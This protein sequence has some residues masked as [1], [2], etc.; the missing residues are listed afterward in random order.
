MSAKPLLRFRL[1]TTAVL[2]LAT[3]AAALAQQY[4]TLPPNS[5]VGN[6]GRPS[7]PSF[8]VSLPEL[9][10]NLYGP[11]PANTILAGAPS[12]SAALPSFRP[13]VPADIPSINSNFTNLAGTLSATQAATVAPTLPLVHPSSGNLLCSQG[14]FL[15]WMD[16]NI[17]SSADNWILNSTD[18]SALMQLTMGGTISNGDIVTLTFTFAGPCAGGCAVNTG[19]LNSGTDTTTTIASKLAAAIQ[20]NSNIYNN[21]AGVQ[22]QVLYVTSIANALYFDYDSRTGM[23]LVASVAGI[24]TETVTFPANS[25]CGTAC[26]TGWDV[27]PTDIR[28]RLPG[29]GVAP[30]ANLGLGIASQLYGL[31]VQSSDSATPNS[32]SV[33]YGTLANFVQNSTHGAVQS[34]WFLGVPSLAGAPGS[35]GIWVG[36]HFGTVQDALPTLTG[37]CGSSPSVLAGSTDNAGTI[38]L[39]T[40]SPTACNLVFA[41]AYSN[42]PYCTVT[43]QSGNSGL[44]YTIATNQISTAGGAASDKVNYVCMGQ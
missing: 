3:T 2:W 41:H 16:Q 4:Q 19:A 22:G 33:Q 8:A 27:N 13:L 28:G 10:A 40:G 42:T 44:A 5:V 36:Q 37:T 7:G 21:V 38:N 17:C 24:A 11:V 43:R 1:L 26:L 15:A 14:H 34:R 32:F 6:L 12:G 39:G 20:A 23:K 18:P 35:I 25:S 31:V 9:A 29:G 30:I